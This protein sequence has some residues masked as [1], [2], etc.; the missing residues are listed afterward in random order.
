[1]ILGDLNTYLNQELD[2]CGGIREVQSESSKAIED[3]CDEFCLFEVY[4]FLFPKKRQ[5][6]WRNKG[7][8]AL[9]QSRLDMFLVSQDFQYLSPKCSITPGIISDHSLVQFTFKQ[10]SIWTRGRVFW[11]F[12]AQFLKDAE[13]VR[14]INSVLSDFLLEEREHDNKSLLWDYIKCKIRGITISHAS[15]IAKQKRFYENNLTSKF[16]SLEME[17]GEADL[18]QSYEDTKAELYQSHLDSTKGSVLRPKAQLVENDIKSIS[19]MQSIEKQN[20]NTNAYSTSTLWKTPL[21]T[22]CITGS[23]FYC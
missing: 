22:S 18:M 6:T 9:I 20:F 13:Y 14:K 12:N 23:L 11:K 16:H 7:R 8:P 21:Y 19:Y 4:R 5:Y 15:Y 1:M 10:N 3:L 2:K 17:L